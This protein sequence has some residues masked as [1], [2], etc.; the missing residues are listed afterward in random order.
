M[1][2]YPFV[3]ERPYGRVEVVLEVYGT[4][5]EMIC[6]IY[7][8]RGKINVRRHFHKLIRAHVKRLER[9]AKQSGCSEMRVAGRNWKRILKDYQP[10]DGVENG[11][12]KAL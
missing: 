7:E 3:I 11:L 12:R 4:G 10:L 8:L 6:G 9:I 2:Q 1:E 5:D